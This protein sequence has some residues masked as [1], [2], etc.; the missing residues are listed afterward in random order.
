M[1]VDLLASKQALA[2]LAENYDKLAKA[3]VKIN[4]SLESDDFLSIKEEKD[5]IRVKLN[6][7]NKEL[8]NALDELAPLAI[9]LLAVENDEY[10]EAEVEFLRDLQVVK[11]KCPFCGYE[12]EYVPIFEPTAYPYT[13]RH[14]GAMVSVVLGDKGDV[15]EAALMI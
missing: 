8:V 2:I 13:C 3:G 14:C 5:E 6:P 1:K 15:V 12:D 10:T 9:T 7:K 11:V 4:I